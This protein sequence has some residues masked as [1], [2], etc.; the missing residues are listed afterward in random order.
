MNA[1]DLTAIEECERL[2]WEKWDSPNHCG[3]AAFGTVPI[4]PRNHQ[5]S[6]RTGL[7][8]YQ[9]LA[10]IHIFTLLTKKE[11]VAQKERNDYY[12]GIISGLCYGVY[13]TLE[14]SGIRMSSMLTS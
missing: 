5:A 13:F 1:N 11:K 12:Y 8:R 3:T 9:T 4:F 2:L 14:A 10:L 7:L 6:Y